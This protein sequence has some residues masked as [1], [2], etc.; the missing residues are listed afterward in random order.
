MKIDNEPD[1]QSH[2]TITHPPYLHP[3]KTEDPS[4]HSSSKIPTYI[5][6]LKTEKWTNKELKK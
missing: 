6:L 3:N 2:G 4:L 5:Y 1:S